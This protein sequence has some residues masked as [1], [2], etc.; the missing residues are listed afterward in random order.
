MTG[1]EMIRQLESRS[2]RFR[3]GYVVWTL[4]QIKGLYLTST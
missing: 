2:G 4:K 3:Y 1:R